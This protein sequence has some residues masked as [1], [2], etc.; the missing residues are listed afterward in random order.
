MKCGPIAYKCDNMSRRLTTLL[1]AI[2]LVLFAVTIVVWARSSVRIDKVE[3]FMGRSLIM[4]ESIEGEI[5]IAVYPNSSHRPRWHATIDE[6]DWHGIW[7][8]HGLRHYAEVGRDAELWTVSYWVIAI[9][10]LILPIW[11]RFAGRV[12][13]RRARRADLSEGGLAARG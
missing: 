8:G 5:E 1:P 13:K 7:W 10:T 6:I 11:R 2:S 9:L 3:L 4:V 12:A